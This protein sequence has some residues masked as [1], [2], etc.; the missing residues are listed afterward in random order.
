MAATLIDGAA[1]AEAIKQEVR[2]RAA[3]LGRPVRLTAILVGAT[4]SAELYANRQADA[5]RNVGIDYHLLK[6]P[7][8]IAQK[9]L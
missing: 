2:T 4:H 6:L 1:L 9:D 8:E 3:A 5:C 7:A